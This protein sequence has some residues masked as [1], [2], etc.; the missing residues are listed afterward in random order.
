LEGLATIGLASSAA[1][2]G[3]WALF[4]D[5]ETVDAT[6]TAGSVELSIN[7]DS[8]LTIEDV[9]DGDEGRD[10]LEVENTGTIPGELGIQVDAVS[11]TDSSGANKSSG[12]KKVEFNGCGSAFVVFDST[13]DLPLD[14][15]GE[16]SE[17]SIEGQITEA[18]LKNGNKYGG[19]PWAVFEAK[20]LKKK[21]R[22]VRIGGRVYH[23]ENNCAEGKS[24]GGNTGSPP[25]GTA[26]LRDALTVEFGVERADS[27][28]DWV[29]E[30]G[31]VGALADDLSDGPVTDYSEVSIGGKGQTATDVVV[32]WRV[33]S[34]GK[35]LAEQTAT[36]DYEVII[37]S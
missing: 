15:V 34:G 11:V 29:L 21:L 3:T 10:S 8:S 32:D 9:A 7:G 5:S 28:I 20:G 14:V 13:A 24:P 19:D 12:V 23:N 17:D 33:R 35:P 1:G 6:I 22:R 4:D 27:T 26:S 25:Q 16:S 37:R 31:T 18:D 30:P 2:A 36:I